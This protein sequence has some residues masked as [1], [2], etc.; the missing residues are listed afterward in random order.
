MRVVAAACDGACRGNPGPGG[1]GCLL[2]FEDGSVRELG[3]AA[4]ATT[5]NRMELTAAL[6]LMEELRQLPL[7]PDLRLR[8][9]SRY[10]IDGL[11]K[12]MAGWKRKGWRTASGGPVLN[13]DLWEELDRARLPGVRLVH[14]K[15][16]SGDPDNDR[17]DEIAV[18]FS[19]GGSPPLATGPGSSGQRNAPQSGAAEVDGLEQ[20]APAVLGELLTRLEVADRLASGGYALTAAELARLVEQPL[21]RL[22]ERQGPWIWRDWRV[23]PASEGR[24]RLERAEPSLQESP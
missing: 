5:N 3:G 19:R 24:W 23:S 10:L 20:P 21:A 13:R 7:H 14:V 1:W 4:A 22:Q 15:G 16:H 12:W 9:D 8:T 2:R 17:C 6:A 18:A 11:T